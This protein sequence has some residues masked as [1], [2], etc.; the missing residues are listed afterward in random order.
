MLG[1]VVSEFMALPVASIANVPPD[2]IHLH[3]ALWHGFTPAFITSLTAIAAGIVIFFARDWVRRFLG[4]F[5]EAM[6]G[7]NLFAGFSNGLYAFARS[8]TRLVQGG[9]L[10]AQASVIIVVAVAVMGY[11]LSLMNWSGNVIDSFRL[12]WTTIPQ[13]QEVTIALLAIVAAVVTV[14]A[15]TRLNQIIS[16]GVVGVMVTLFFV[17][18][19]APD[20][21]LT[22][23][24]IET[25]TLV[26]LVL[27][28]YKIPPMVSTPM[29][30]SLRVRNLVVSIIAG[31]FGIGLV[32]F[33]A[34]QPYAQPISD[35]FSLN[36]VSQAHGANI[37]NVILVDF[38]GFDTMG[39]ITVLTIAALGGYAL[40]RSSRLRPYKN[41][42]PKDVQ[43]LAHKQENKK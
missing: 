40:L 28:F 42:Q 10:A 36:S 13:I 7:A 43:N 29:A 18:F 15:G 1:N 24:L 20:L 21:A 16:M 8:I 5:P 25:L 6:A 9:T 17:F 37:V 12:D 33:A 2:D 27:V 39:E 35:F 26:L 41:T 22:Q 23:L 31:L 32:L 30:L 3:L 38:R 34:G 14:R 4:I 11:A 19:S